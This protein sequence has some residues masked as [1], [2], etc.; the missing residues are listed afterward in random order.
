MPRLDQIVELEKRFLLPIYNRYLVGFECG[1]SLRILKK[2]LGKK[3][4][5]SDTAVSAAVASGVAAS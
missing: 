1:K 3:R 2:L 4:K 5:K